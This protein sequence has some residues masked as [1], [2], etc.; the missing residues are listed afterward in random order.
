MHN[1][2][3]VGK[4]LGSPKNLEITHVTENNPS[5]P[6][7][8]KPLPQKVP[9]PP[10]NQNQPSHATFGTY[11]RPS[12]FAAKPLPQQPVKNE[13]KTPTKQFYGAQTNTKQYG[14][15]PSFPGVGGSPLAGRNIFPI[16]SLNPYQN[17]WEL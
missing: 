7:S 8:S 10:P 6:P 11:Q 14:G 2:S 1:G 3:S 12:N 15:S 13:Q 16:A 9:R 4:V 5:A 17:K